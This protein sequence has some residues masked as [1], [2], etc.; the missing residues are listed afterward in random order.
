MEFKSFKETFWVSRSL[1]GME[2]LVSQWPSIF[3]LLP[4]ASLLCRCVGVTQTVFRV[5]FFFFQEN[6]VHMQLSI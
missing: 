5:F 2:C 1:P 3:Y 4:Q 6:M